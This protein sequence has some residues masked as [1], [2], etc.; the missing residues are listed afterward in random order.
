LLTMM[1]IIMVS[2]KHNSD[3]GMIGLQCV[4]VPNRT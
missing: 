3:N 2:A 1:L 4:V